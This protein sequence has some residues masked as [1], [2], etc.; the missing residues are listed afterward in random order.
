VRALIITHGRLGEELLASAR[1]VYDIDAPV[2]FLSNRDCDLPDLVAKIE[3]WLAEVEGPALLL[4]D[5]GGGSCGVAAQKAV[6]DRAQTWVIGGLNMPMLLT[7]LS[8]HADLRPEDLIAKM[9]DRALNAVDRL[10][11][12]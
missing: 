5:V 6:G 3:N 9:L 7:Y 12:N 11:G 8:S 4:V 2:D 10:G 1:E